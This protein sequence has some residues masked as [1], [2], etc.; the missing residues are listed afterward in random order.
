[1]LAFTTEVV[2]PGCERNEYL[3]CGEEVGLFQGIYSGRS[4]DL[5]LLPAVI[6]HVF[7]QRSFHIL[8]M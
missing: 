1:M 7:N 4:F 2:Q 6:S 8:F 5:N 3:A